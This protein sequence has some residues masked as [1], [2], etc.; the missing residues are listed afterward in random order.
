MKRLLWITGLLLIACRPALA[1]DGYEE[2]EYMTGLRNFRHLPLDSLWQYGR[3][4]AELRR[5]PNGPLVNTLLLKDGAGKALPWAGAGWFRKTF[6]VPDSLRGKLIACRMGHYGASAVYLDGR[7]VQRYG[8]IAASQAAERTYIPHKPFTATLSDKTTH[9]WVVHYTNHQ[10][11]QPTRPQLM[12]GFWLSMAPVDQSYQ[13]FAFSAYHYVISSSF[14]VAFCVFFCFVYAFYPNRLASL[15]AAL[16][17]GNFAL[18]FL[19]YLAGSITSDGQLYGILLLV[20]RSAVVMLQSWLVLYL[21]SLYY[22]R[23]PRLT[24]LWVGLM[25]TGVFLVLHPVGSKVSLVP[26]ALLPQV[27]QF[28]MLLLGLREKKPGFQILVIGS[29]LNLVG[30]MC[31]IADVTGFF[32]AYYRSP[33]QEIGGILTDLV[34]PLMLALQ[35][36]WEFG[37]A[38][39]VLTRQ[40]VQVKQLSAENLAKEQEKQHLLA[41]QNETLERQV[42]QR[43]VE[44]S[45]SLTELKATQ[46]QLIQQEKLASLGELTA[47]IAHEIQNPLNFVTNFSEV[48][49]ELVSELEMEQEKADRDPALEKEILGDLKDNLHKI[50][51]H[52]GRASNIV[53]GMLEHSRTSTG[54]RQPT[55]LNALCQE[56]LRLSYQGM[57][58]KD[59]A[60]SAELTTD[61]DAN[62]RPIAVVPHEIG[63][64]VLNLVNNAFYAVSETRKQ[65]HKAGTAASYVP[66]VSVSTH[67]GSNQAEIRVRD[68]GSGIPDAMKDKIFQPF[69]TTKPTGQ[70]TG[71][72]LSLSHDII[73]KGYGGTLS[74]SSM[75]HEQT[76]F[77]ISL[78]VASHGQP[79]QPQATMV[80]QTSQPSPI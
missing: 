25:A 13:P 38:N 49:T 50:T 79:E 67:Y 76:T 42:T 39:R 68:N 64:V 8:T 9:E 16:V 33:P 24:W 75:A 4:P 59:S 28:R 21:Y 48:S 40:V 74:V 18:I 29:L 80:H 53:K 1:Q 27:E 15:M 69:F 56:Y 51:H 36:A 22:N 2:I 11:D 3:N 17:L 47:G 57:R 34:I 26:F 60:F 23:L 61:F 19:G 32:P 54:E 30:F 77:I 6:T 35:L 14:L 63:R 73:T 5:Q 43:T 65:H 20:W 58:V 7:L 70:G 78:P 52:G 71:L 37:S 12:K 45:Q 66:T 44:L 46:A 10:F 41:S 62:L 31:F 72:G 55:D